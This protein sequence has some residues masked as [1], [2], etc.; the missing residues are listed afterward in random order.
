MVAASILAEMRC[1]RALGQLALRG[2]MTWEV[3]FEADFGQTFEIGSRIQCDKASEG[4]KKQ[5]QVICLFL[6]SRRVIQEHSCTPAWL[7][8]VNDTTRTKCSN[9]WSAGDVDRHR[10]CRTEGYLGKS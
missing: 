9:S 5:C 8:I 6:S 3:I 2:S 1:E 10:G 7:E 4:E